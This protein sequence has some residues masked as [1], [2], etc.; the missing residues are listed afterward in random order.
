MREHAITM[1]QYSVRAILDENKHMSRRLPSP[2]NIRVVTEEGRRFRPD[3]AMVRQALTDVRDLQKWGDI[4][5]WRAK[6]YDYQ[7]PAS[8]TRW[9]V[10]PFVEVGDR[11]WVKETWRRLRCERNRE[12]PCLD[13]QSCQSPFEYSADSAHPGNVRLDAGYGKGELWRSPRFMPR[14]AS[15]I[16]LEVTEVRIE[17]LGDITPADALAEGVWDHCPHL[18]DGRRIPF[19]DDADDPAYN[20][21]AACGFAIS[22]YRRL[23][24]SLNGKRSWDPDRLVLVYGFRRVEADHAE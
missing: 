14:A 2:E 16:S 22:N 11:F 10:R 24:E 3:K 17:R 6:A 1:C 8:L 7:A 4:Y 19:E 18:A 13:C 20:P 23:F 21:P 15:R 12:E 9:M 5:T